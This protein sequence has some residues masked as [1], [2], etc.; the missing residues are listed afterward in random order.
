MKG[1]S[2]LQKVID[3]INL[4]PI[5]KSH[6]DDLVIMNE[7]CTK[8][9]NQ[10]IKKLTERQLKDIEV[11]APSGANIYLTIPVPY[12]KH[13]KEVNCIT[14]EHDALSG[15]SVCLYVDFGHTGYYKLKKRHDINATKPNQIVTEFAKIYKAYLG[16][17]T[18]NL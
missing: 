13:I 17:E 11:D 2:I 14:L 3:E 12:Q 8:I 4:D 1:T 6:D 18:N 9:Q 7:L 10:E 5:I 16:K 15:W